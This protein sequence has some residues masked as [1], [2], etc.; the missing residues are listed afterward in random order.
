MVDEKK[1]RSFLRRN[2]DLILIFSIFIPFYYANIFTQPKSPFEPRNESYAPYQRHTYFTWRFPFVSSYFLMLPENYNPQKHTYPTVM[3]L[4]GVSRHMYGGKV[5]SRPEMRAYFPFIVII[6]IA[7]WGY[8]WTMPQKKLLRPEA[9]PIAMDILYSVEKNYSV[10]RN[11]IYITGYSMGGFGVYGAL[12]RYHGV[13]AAAI[14][15]D[16][17]WEPAWAVNM[18]NIPMWIFNGKQDNQMP[19]EVARSLAT[20]LKQ[21]GRDVYYTEFPKQGHG[22]WIQAYENPKLWA[23]LTSQSKV[24]Q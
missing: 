3:M 16:A 14:P 5:L 12:S 8:A 15:T 20:E 24:S 10:D 17:V 2:R 11:K 1:R 9:L 18:D 7:P 22:V 21:Q 4:H 23:W 6:P 13:F 19:V